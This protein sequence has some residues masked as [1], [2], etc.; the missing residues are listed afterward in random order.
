MFVVAAST[1]ATAETLYVARSAAAGGDGSRERPLRSIQEAIRR[2]HDGDL[3]LVGAGVYEETLRFFGRRVEIRSVEGSDHTVI[4][5]RRSGSAVQFVDGETR[6][7]QLVGFLVTGGSGEPTSLGTAGGGVLVIDASPTLRDVR[8]ERNGADAGG[9]LAAF[10]GAPRIVDCDVTFNEAR[11]T[12]G[13][14]FFENCSATVERCAFRSNRAVG[15]R[16][17]PTGGA[18]ACIGGRLAF[19]E[20]SVERN[21]AL[22]G[23]GGAIAL[24]NDVDALVRAVRFE[25]NMASFGTGGAIAV[26][27]GA[28]LTL[29]DSLLAGNEADSGGGVGC[30]TAFLALYGNRIRSNRAVE[31]V[32]GERDGGGG[33]ALFEDSS[34]VLDGD[35]L[36]DNTA[37][38]VGGLRPSVGGAIAVHESDLRLVGVEVYDNRAAPGCGGSA[39][40]ADATV[41]SRV[42]VYRNNAALGR[43]NLDPT[44]VARGG[45]WYLERCVATFEGDRIDANRAALP[46]SEGPPS[47][48]RGCGG[49]LSCDDSVV[50]LRSTMVTRNFA[51]QHGG[52][53]EARDSAFE[54]RHT[55]FAANEAPV[56]LAWST[57]RTRVD[58]D[59]SIITRSLRGD[60]LSRHARATLIDGSDGVLSETSVRRSFVDGK[61]VGGPYADELRSDRHSRDIS[62]LDPGFVSVSRGDFRLRLGSIC[63]DLLAAPIDDIPFDVDGEA[64][65][66]DGDRDGI[67]LPDLGAAEAVPEVAVRYGSVLAPSG[68]LEDLLTVNGSAGDS[69]RSLVLQ[70][71]EPWRVDLDAPATGPSQA[72]YAIYAW[73]EEPDP[74]TLTVLPYHAGLIGHPLPGTPESSGDPIAV[75]NTLGHFPIL[76]HPTETAAPAPTTLVERPR[77]IGLATTITLQGLIE[78]DRAPNGIAVTNAIIL[79][80][81]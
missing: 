77:G 19:S 32:E 26:L 29:H 24:A 22:N 57:S 70:R 79:H 20:S 1:F 30:R 59:G 55:T 12:G 67:A 52:G 73:F 10:G 58:V 63:I 9:G 46:S 75:W 71:H 62:N 6:E 49:A 25:S 28:I 38:F 17:Y 44:T 37:T 54:G 41:T 18:G 16:N 60:A 66:A 15:A 33:I 56:G 65:V 45:A 42:S 7:S 47:E 76:G 34:G 23:D 40:G 72:A 13:G 74:L 78:S 51:G 11:L 61:F 50:H 80:I 5:A 27:D 21:T 36:H 48:L 68:D 8:I 4:D 3:V 53:I 43:P 2:S 35:T 31:R 69:R 81:R 39:Y 64:R 14:W